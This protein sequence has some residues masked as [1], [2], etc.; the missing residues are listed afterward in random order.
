MASRT[1]H[2]I[3]GF[4]SRD[5]LDVA[6][7]A[8][9][10]EWKRGEIPGLLPEKIQDWP[11]EAQQDRGF[12]IAETVESFARD[13]ALEAEYQIRR[14]YLRKAGSLS[15][16]EARQK[17]QPG[18]DLEIQDKEAIIQRTI[19]DFESLISLK[20]PHLL[21]DDLGFKCASFL[22]SLFEKARELNDPEGW[23]SRT[24]SEIQIDTGLRRTAQRSASKKLVDLGILEEEPSEQDQK[25]FFRINYER[26]G[27]FLARLIKLNPSAGRRG[28]WRR[29]SD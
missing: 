5:A 7:L 23:L 22:A 18:E 20:V 1:S 14:R 3:R 24:V 21:R 15:P 8:V 9:R 27:V 19:R 10:R 16:P 2:I 11:E 6:S 13:L 25:F 29:R 17:H 12:F 4:E 28:C 26:L